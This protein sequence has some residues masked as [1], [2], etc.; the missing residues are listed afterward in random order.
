VFARFHRKKI[1]EKED[2]T[3]FFRSQ[4]T[5][6]RRQNITKVASIPFG[7]LHTIFPVIE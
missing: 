5:L 6:P 3:I 4:S 1:P 2:I 7:I